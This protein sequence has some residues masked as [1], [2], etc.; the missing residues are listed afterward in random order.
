MAALTS[1][2]AAVAATPF[3]SIST[4]VGI[5]AGGALMTGNIYLLRRVVIGMLGEEPRSAK[6]AKRKRRRLLL[7]YMVKMIGLL[8]VLGGLILKTDISPA[9][10]LT[11]VTAAIIGL[12]YVGLRDADIEE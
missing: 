8:V 12:M 4:T 1:G 11:G 7:V 6:E 2:L 5:A 9:G 10:L 3:V